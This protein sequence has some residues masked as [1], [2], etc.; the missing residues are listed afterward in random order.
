MAPLPQDTENTAEP[1]FLL[2]TDYWLPATAFPG[3]HTGCGWRRHNNPSS[4][5]GDTAP[6][7]LSARAQV[8]LACDIRRNGVPGA[9]VPPKQRSLEP[10]QRVVEGWGTLRKVAW[11]PPA[12]RRLLTGN[13]IGWRAI[14]V[15]RRRRVVAHLLRSLG[16]ESNQLV[17]L[18][19]Q[20]VRYEQGD[21]GRSPACCQVVSLTCVESVHSKQAFGNAVVTDGYVLER[22]FKSPLV[23]AIDPRRNE[24]HG[25]AVRLVH[26]SDNSSP[27][28]CCGARSA[29]DAPAGG[30]E[31]PEVGQHAAINRR[32]ER[33]VGVQ[34]P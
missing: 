20:Y 17:G 10:A 24:A 14:A 19:A 4:H 31:E 7:L 26:Q 18:F 8:T 34:S 16:R 30:D 6:G 28:G 32:V 27:G 5:F 1:R 22:L 15:L 21:V 25:K 23:Q 9:G 33:Y 12:L 3:P 2:A 11:C 13:P 29:E